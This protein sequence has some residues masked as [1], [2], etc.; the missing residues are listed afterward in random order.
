MEISVRIAPSIVLTV[1]I[2]LIVVHTAAAAMPQSAAWLLPCFGQQ[3]AP[4]VSPGSETAMTTR[5]PGFDEGDPAAATKDPRRKLGPG[6]ERTAALAPATRPTS[7][8]PGA[9]PWRNGRASYAPRGEPR[10]GRP[11][12]TGPW[13]TPVAQSPAAVSAAG[14]ETS[15]PAARGP[16]PPAYGRAGYA[17][18]GETD[19]CAAAA[20]RPVQALRQPRHRGVS[21][22]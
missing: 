9:G 5:P 3:P 7:Q 1:V 8:P 4:D 15:R 20:G 6:R 14:N 22:R 21:R 19:E 2:V 17:P 10:L 18:R 13:P 11:P 16:A 12:G